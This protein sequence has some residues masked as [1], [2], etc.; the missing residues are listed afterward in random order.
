MW[1]V[2]RGWG[3]RV[4][5]G[6]GLAV[7]LFSSCLKPAFH[8][9]EG[10]PG[11]GQEALSSE[12]EQYILQGRYSRALA[13]SQIGSDATAL[14]SLRALFFDLRREDGR[15]D[16]LRWKLQL[17]VTR[18]MVRLLERTGPDPKF[19]E[20]YSSLDFQLQ[21]HSDSLRAFGPM[22]RDALREMLGEQAADLEGDSL[23][24]EV[25]ESQDSFT[26]R[27]EPLPDIPDCDRP[28]VDGMVEY[29]VNGRG[30]NFY[31]IWLDRYPDVVP[32][33]LRILQEE[34]MP[35][36][37]IYLAM[38]ES[39]LKISATSRAKARGP[40]QFITGTAHLFDL[41]VDYWMDERLDLERSTRAACRFLRKLYARYDDWYL[42][43]AAY[44]WGPG[45]IDRA[46]ARGARDYW[47][48]P[49]MPNETRNYVPTYLAA[50]RVFQDLDD[51][52]FS[53]APLPAP[54]EIEPLPIKGS[55]PLARLSDLFAIDEEWMRQWNH[56]L[57]QGSTPPNG[58]HVYVPA[59]QAALCQD[60]LRELPESV[61]LKWVRHKVKRGESVSSVARHYGVSGEDLRRANNLSAKAKLKA[62]HTLQIPLES[63]GRGEGAIASSPREG[64]GERRA[65]LTHRVRRGE[66][67]SGL[68]KHYGMSVGELAAANGLGSKARL[69]T[70]QSLRIPGRTPD[71][72]GRAVA[73]EQAEARAASGERTVHQIQSGETLDQIARRHGLSVAD[74]S[75]WNGLSTTVIHPGQ[76]LRLTDP[77]ASRQD[78]EVGAAGSS[79]TSQVAARD[80]RPE[81]VHVVKAGETA[82]SIARHHGIRLNDLIKANQL[83]RKATIRV[84]QRLRIPVAAG[85]HGQASPSGQQVIHVV[86]SGES[87]WG[88]AKHYKVKVDDIRRW[89]NLRGSDIHAGSRLVIILSEE[90]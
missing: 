9:L 63:T 17:Q 6:A 38:I 62:G 49:K 22:A 20:G 5:F 53:L 60:Q 15:L 70:G 75:A 24:A 73:G 10:E 14:D 42:A 16:S 79:S 7:L 41:R 51:H 82:G 54:P 25:L 85:G 18:E 33:I 11:P 84:G 44:N 43:M 68:A 64:G 67:L 21:Y 81:R 48:I 87:L 12:D 26:I 57:V 37:L 47:S 72:G 27:H 45:R 8:S 13:L 39:G 4:V 34:G 71:T 3:Q 28:E 58:G 88:L 52:G 55:I 83:G 50:R 35:A 36:D 66:T 90:G 59:E 46:V 65:A 74:L 1:E 23:L 69:R 19:E 2:R 61:Y 89:N 31:Q 78:R 76:Q 30:R 80:A 86:R 40:W 77:G 32:L 56:H 29:F